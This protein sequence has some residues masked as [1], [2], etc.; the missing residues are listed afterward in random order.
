[1][2]FKNRNFKVN[3]KVEEERVDEKGRNRSKVKRRKS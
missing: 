1:M 3:R 2:K